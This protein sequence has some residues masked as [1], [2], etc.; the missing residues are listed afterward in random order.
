M[1]SLIF[2]SPQ[3]CAIFSLSDKYFSKGMLSQNTIVLSPRSS[4]FLIKYS[5]MNIFLGLQLY[6]HM[7]LLWLSRS[8][9]A[10]CWYMARQNSSVMGH[11]TY[12][13]ISTLET[14]GE[15]GKIHSKR[16]EKIHLYTLHSCYVTSVLEVSPIGLVQFWP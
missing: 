9:E 15:D 2:T 3:M 16:V 12:G 7:H 13:T 11:Q 14:G 8:E 4:C 6:R 10:I 5:I 1:R